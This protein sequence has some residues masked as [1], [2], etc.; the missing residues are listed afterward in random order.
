MWEKRGKSANAYVA[1]LAKNDV[2]L[3]L[4]KT[5][6]RAR[7]EITIPKIFKEEFTNIKNVA[8]DFGVKVPN[9]QFVKN[10][11][12]R[13]KHIELGST[14]VPKVSIKSIKN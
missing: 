6:K 9:F 1:N 11:L 8:S 13:Q 3:C 10:S 12:Y 7:E 5:K 4:Y 14:N 2:S